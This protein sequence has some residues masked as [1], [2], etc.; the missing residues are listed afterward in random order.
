[1]PWLCC[2]GSGYR[3]VESNDNNGDVGERKVS[4]GDPM[5]E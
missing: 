5:S 2:T 3:D 1:M 4:E